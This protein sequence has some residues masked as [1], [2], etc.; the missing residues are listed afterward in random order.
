[1]SVLSATAII[2]TFN[3]AAFLPEAIESLLAQSVPLER[4]LVVDDGSTDATA[5]TVARYGSRID[6]VHKPNGGKSSALNL[7][8]RQVQT[9]FVWIF[10]DDDVAAPRALEIM[11]NAL[12]E[13]P[14]S[15]FSYGPYKKFRTA[16]DG[17]RIVIDHDFPSVPPEGLFV[18][19][20][21]RCF[22]HQQ[23]LLVRR[24]CYDAL[25]PFDETLIRS[26]D[27]EM[28]LR[29][30]RRYRG[31]EVPGPLFFQREHVGDRGT[32]NHVIR[33]AELNATW[34]RFDQRFMQRLRDVCAL[35]EFLPY[36]PVRLP[37]TGQERLSA[38]LER[39][40]ILGRRSL[41]ALAAEDLEAAV[42]ISNIQQIEH[43]TPMQSQILHRMFDVY[44]YGDLRFHEAG[45]FR[46]ALARIRCSTL[47]HDMRLAMSWGLPY[48]I[49]SAA[50]ACNLADTARLMKVYRQVASPR[51]LAVDIARK[52]KVR[53]PSTPVG[54][55]YPARV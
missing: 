20:M 27:Y 22:F 52:L 24:H 15:G 51:V 40:T 34:M 18:A 55:N 47:A 44:S 26:Q 13:A 7:A 1:M 30:A 9:E 19:L 35:E 53:V 10:D 21:G 23:G 43:L 37:L 38:L 49:R 33:T 42:S 32:Q 12:I 4:I 8:L 11:S 14:A 50:T 2:P 45:A 16:A 17:S 3:R 25:G 6:Y 41:W 46:R 5:L 36:R 31:V 48:R 39:C 29:L 54:V 28:M